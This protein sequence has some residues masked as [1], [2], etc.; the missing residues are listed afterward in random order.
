M[1]N[2]KNNWGALQIMI[3]MDRT[4]ISRKA[5]QSLN[6]IYALFR[7]PIYKNCDYDEFGKVRGVD[8]FSSVIKVA[9][10]GFNDG[11]RLFLDTILQAGQMPNRLIDVTVYS[12]NMEDEKNDY[13]STRPS[14][15]SFV[16]IDDMETSS[17]Y[18]HI[19]F[20]QSKW[21]EK[22]KTTIEFFDEISEMDYVL[23]SEDKKEDLEREV[24]AILKENALKYKPVLLKAHYYENQIEL[25]KNDDF[26]ELERIAFNS[27]LVW[28][29]TL[30]IDFSDVKER[31]NDEYNY[32]SSL[33]YAL[34]I[35]YKLHSVG[36]ELKPDNFR[37]LAE[38]FIETVNNYD[39][40]NAEAKGIISEMAA[41]EH[42][43]WVAE[44]ICDGWQRLELKDIN[45]D[46]K[47]N[48]GKADDQFKKYHYCIANGGSDNPLA[49]WS[50]DDWDSKS[51]DDLDNLDK[52]SVIAHRKLLEE[53]EQIAIQVIFQ[54]STIEK[55]NKEA[56][57]SEYKDWKACVDLIIHSNAKRI[58]RPYYN[59][60]NRLLNTIKSNEFKKTIIEINNK[61]QF[62]IKSRE[63][64]NQKQKDIDL[65]KQ[66]PFILSFNTNLN[67]ACEFTH[68]DNSRLFSNVSI[69][70]KFNPNSI[71]YFCEYYNGIDKDINHF[72][73][74]ID[75]YKWLR[76]KISFAFGFAKNEEQKVDKLIDIFSLKVTKIPYD[77]YY[78]YISGIGE[79]NITKEFDTVIYNNRTLGYNLRK[80]NSPCGYYIYKEGRFDK[81]SDILLRSV[82]FD[83]SMTIQDILRI[84]GAEG[85]KRTVPIYLEQAYQ[86][87]N[88]SNE[89]KTKWKEICKSLFDL[90]K[91]S[92][93]L[94]ID[95]GA[96][97]DNSIL[98][99]LQEMGL[100]TIKSQGGSRILS[101]ADR[102]TKD[103]LTKE[104]EILEIHIYNQCI[105]SGLFDDVATGYEIEWED[106]KVTNEFDI[107]L[108]KGLKSAF[109]EIKSTSDYSGP[110]GCGLRQEYYE[111]LESLESKFGINSYEFLINDCIKTFPGNEFLPGNKTQISR[112]EQFGIKT[113]VPNEVEKSAI[114][115]KNTMDSGSKLH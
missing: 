92:E 68:S 4:N 9:I 114:I 71:M 23:F 40:N 56:N 35:K 45:A 7:N 29:N 46:D 91:N 104:G 52:A 111:K 26:F 78:D 11:G 21:R 57:L 14:L 110:T 61:F 112:G 67:L 22:A 101:F 80:V 51:V 44:K 95:I 43:R 53:S 3:L 28:E 55:E 73:D 81:Q 31:F 6:F 42:R 86:I 99:A 97:Q 10:V 13:L 88:G 93:K 15:S 17:L 82:K 107:L 47:H 100:I 24:G 83:I 36:L 1:D 32:V 108:V 79:N 12:S 69:L 49:N 18:G 84:N 106:G 85:N 2:H 98:K 20:K 105:A 65:V 75:D 115:I 27:H 25:N 19:S 74:C 48:K 63:Y 30:E 34:S 76:T 90:S 103:M 77:D 37:D 102:K 62:V 38:E 109:I 16:D 94:E 87:Y 60:Y 64:D 5:L 70:K 41:A 39:A 33:T 8:D 58:C 59:A 113:I 66:I 89:S 50:G 54:L 72:F 96:K